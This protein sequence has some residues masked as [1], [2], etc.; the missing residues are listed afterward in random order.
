MAETERIPNWW[1]TLQ[2]YRD[3]VNAIARHRALHPAD[4]IYYVTNRRTATL[5]LSLLEQAQRW[6]D[7]CFIGG[8]GTV[9]IV[10]P[11]DEFKTRVYKVLDIPVFIDD[12]LTIVKQATRGQRAYLLARPWNVEGRDG[13]RIVDS[14]KQ[15][16]EA[17]G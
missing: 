15:F 12:N 11:P 16:L 5:G 8:R 7:Q 6:L 13:V 10:V 2:A 4:E 3:S 1:L 14:V 17:T 9:V